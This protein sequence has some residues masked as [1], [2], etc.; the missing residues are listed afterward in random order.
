MSYIKKI[1]GNI[2]V[3]RVNDYTKNIKSYQNLTKDKQLLKVNFYLNQ[4]LP[5]YDDVIQKQE[6]YWASP[7]EFLITG[8][9]DCEDYV[10]IKYFTLLKLGFD[11]DKLFFTTVYEKYI[12]GYHMVLSYF[13]VPGKSPI[14]LDNL[15][16]RILPLNVRKDLK[17]D[18]FINSIG[19]Y[20]IDKNNK[21]FKVQD[22][23]LKFQK[24]LK[25]VK[26]EI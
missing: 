24:L 22:N 26:K 25:K 7:K 9:G 17:A 5:Q 18:T 16:F 1:S 10:I 6:D 15:S 14:I 20:K 13:K 8:F 11:K 12:G 4:L 3:N 19:I 23:S 21:L 2:A